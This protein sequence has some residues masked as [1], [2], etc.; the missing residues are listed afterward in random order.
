MQVLSGPKPAARGYRA[1]A[2]PLYGAEICRQGPQT[3]SAAPSPRGSTSRQDL[4]VDA[5]T[6]SQK[7]ALDHVDYKHLHSADLHGR[8]HVELICTK[9][10]WQCTQG[11]GGNVPAALQ[12]TRMC[13][14]H[15]GEARDQR[16]RPWVVKLEECKLSAPDSPPYFVPAVHGSSLWANPLLC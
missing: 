14:T 2:V 5:T 9:I 10:A 11:N 12:V 16:G 15:Q 7:A 6:A 1:R 13:R 3:L 4:S 8:F